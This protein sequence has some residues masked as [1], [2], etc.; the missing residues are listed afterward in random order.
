M[1]VT[2]TGVDGR[3]LQSL[4]G[5]LRVPAIC[6]TGASPT[7]AVYLTVPGLIAARCRQLLESFPTSLE[8]D[9]IAFGTTE[10]PLRTAI[11]YRVGKKRILAGALAHF[12][13]QK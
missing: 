5:A 13:L 1:V 7:A 12:E 2:A 10:D 9:A 8:E 4:E 3:M 6:N 11:Q